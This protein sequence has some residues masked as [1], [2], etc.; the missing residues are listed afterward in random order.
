MQSRR[1]GEK[2]SSPVLIPNTEFLT[3]KQSCFI[4]LYM[5]AATDYAT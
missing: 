3:Q 4:Y 1:E 2:K 5:H